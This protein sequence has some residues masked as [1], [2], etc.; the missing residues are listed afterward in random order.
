[1]MTDMRSEASLAVSASDRRRLQEIVADRNRPQRNVWRARIILFGERGL[2]TMAVV[3]ETGRSKRCVWPRQE[4]FM[5]EGV[6]GLLRDRTRPPGKPPV[7]PEKTAEIVDLTYRLPHE[8][9][10]WTVR[11]M[12]KATGVAAST[13]WTIWR[14]HGLAPHR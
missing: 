1:M 10:R 11:A 6:D 2:G 13:V 7:S 14:A 3:R 5:Q 8:A 12:A 4:C 9:T